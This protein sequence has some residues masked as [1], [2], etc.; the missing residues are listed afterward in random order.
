MQLTQ[1]KGSTG[2]T[3]PDTACTMP[4]HF[5]YN[6]RSLNA[7]LN[8]SLRG[9]KGTMTSICGSTLRTKDI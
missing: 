3:Q 5:R 4:P 8:M 7:S 2:H 1:R 6:N 9:V